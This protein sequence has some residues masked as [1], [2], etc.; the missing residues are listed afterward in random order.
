MLIQPTLERLHAMRLGGRAEALRR[1]L[2]DDLDLA[3][4]SAMLVE[5][6]WPWKESRALTRRLA[7]ARLKQK[8]CLEDIDFRH[9]RGIG[10]T[11]LTCALA[12]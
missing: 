5:S 3:D 7:L 8:A 9:A 11:Y 1:Q 6:Q 10:K 4:R 12:P 2:E